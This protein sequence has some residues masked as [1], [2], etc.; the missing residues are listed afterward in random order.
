[1]GYEV[2]EHTAD[3]RLRIWGRGEEQ[4][5][6]EALMAMM[7]V[8]K[9]KARAMKH[10]K[11]ARNIRVQSQDITSLLVDFLNE[12]LTLS[13]TNKEVYT[14]ISFKRLDEQEIQAELS[15]FSV[16]KFEEDIKAV[17]YHEADIRKN[18]EGNL[19]TN[20]VLDV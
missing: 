13:Q 14:E 16:P 1:M 11:K 5:F 2:L 6:R 9:P 8:M 10:E 7:E 3:L 12:V 17:T 20:L 4:L 19:E 15:G 18:A